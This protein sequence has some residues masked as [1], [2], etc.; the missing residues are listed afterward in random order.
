VLIVDNESLVRNLIRTILTA[1]GLEVVGEADDGDQVL[2]AI[3]EHRPD[4][5]LMD[6]GMERVG[7]VEAIRQVKALPDAPPCIALTSFGSEEMIGRA[8][9]AGAAGF[10]SK[11]DDP[12]TWA[13]HVQAVV[14]GGGAF[15]ASAARTL[16]QQIVSP[17]GGAADK[18]AEAQAALSVLTDKERA[19]VA[20]VGS[21]TNGQI[22]PR[23][24]MSPHTVKSHIGHA[25][26]KLGLRTRAE[27]AVLA[28]RAGL[29]DQ[30]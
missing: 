17:D 25:F 13:V 1:R 27:L 15:G 2:P 28:D 6:L 3:A 5:V 22:A 16:I 14:E 10:L 24:G 7:G 8:L 20:L 4:V 29:S 21:L 26:D 11:D 23:L 30:G 9:E 19:V 12:E 18:T